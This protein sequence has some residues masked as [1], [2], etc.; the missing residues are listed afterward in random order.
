MAFADRQNYLTSALLAAACLLLAVA[1]VVEW[2]QLFDWQ[3]SGSSV[4]TRPSQPPVS[5]ELKKSHPAEITTPSADEYSDMVERPLFIPGRQPL[6]D[7][8][9]TAEPIS[10]PEAVVK[11]KVLDSG[12]MLM[13]VY[14]R[15]EQMIAMF[16]MPDGKYSKKKLAETLEV[17]SFKANPRVAR[18]RSLKSAKKFD[19]I[20][21]GKA[22]KED[23]AMDGWIL[24]EIH[25]DHVVLTSGGN[26]EVIS[27]WEPR[28]KGHKTAKPATKRR[29]KK[30]TAKNKPP[31]KADDSKADKKKKSADDEQKREKTRQKQQKEPSKQ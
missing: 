23:Q 26:E 27:L 1:A 22:V 12:L 31:D 13:G 25:S 30:H 29:G 5:N 2:Q 20:K 4:T 7:Q 15:G 14:S 3:K 6:E 11:E 8:S 10:E 28:P 16:L 17:P 19:R 24:K 18:R 21:A 9:P